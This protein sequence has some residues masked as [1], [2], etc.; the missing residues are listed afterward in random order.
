MYGAMGVRRG[1]LPLP[2]AMATI[3]E[4]QHRSCGQNDSEKYGGQLIYGRI[5]I[6]FTHLKNAQKG[7][8]I[9]VADEVTKLLHQLEFEEEILSKKRYMYRKCLQ[10][11]S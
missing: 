4:E 3:W 9:E 1:Y 7:Y 5:A 10:M 11:C 8:A 6:T 2:G